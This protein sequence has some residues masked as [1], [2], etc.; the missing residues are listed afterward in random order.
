[1]LVDLFNVIAIEKYVCANILGIA[2]AT[3]CLKSYNIIDIKYS[4]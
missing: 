3:K 1:M 2:K 4:E